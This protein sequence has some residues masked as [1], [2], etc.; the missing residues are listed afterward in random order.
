MKTEL[1]QLIA[2][3]EKEMLAIEANTVSGVMIHH[4]LKRSEKNDKFKWQKLRYTKTCAKEV[5]YRVY[6][7]E[8]VE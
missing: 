7:E 5:L 4:S 1:K 8:A 2:N 3:C 6:G